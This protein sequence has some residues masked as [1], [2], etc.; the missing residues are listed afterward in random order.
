MISLSSF[1]TD[2]MFVNQVPDLNC[3]QVSPEVLS[4]RHSPPRIVARKLMT[5]EVLVLRLFLVTSRT[6]LRRSH[7]PASQATGPGMAR[8][9]TGRLL[10]SE[11]IPGALPPLLL[12]FSSSSC[13]A[14]T[15][16]AS[17]SCTS[18]SFCPTVP[19]STSPPFAA[20]V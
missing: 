4:S 1:G 16:S 13:S 19:P 18:S 9:S 10:D 12:P 14:T 11:M 17:S 8:I 5:N 6:S 2:I 7:C 3:S 15:S 20:C